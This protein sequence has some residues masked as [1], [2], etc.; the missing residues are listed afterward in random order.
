[1]K[2][3]DWCG[4]IFEESQAEKAFMQKYRYLYYPRLRVRLCAAC[5]VT[6][7]ENYREDIYY[8]TCDECGKK[9]DY[10][11]E[12]DRFFAVTG[13]PLHAA[14]RGGVLCRQCALRVT[15]Y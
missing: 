2:K 15:V 12:N 3:C 11:V 13:M 9:F 7:F 6:A 14:W 8:D 5:A 10:T 4:A 1:M